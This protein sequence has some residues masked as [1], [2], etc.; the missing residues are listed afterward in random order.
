LASCSTPASLGRP[1]ATVGSTGMETRHASAHI[2]G[3]VGRTDCSREAWPK[4]SAAVPCRSHLIAAAHVCRGP[5]QDSPAFDPLMPQAARNVRF[6]RVPA[7]KAYD[8]GHNHALCRR[9][10]GVRTTAIP[11]NPRAHPGRLPKTPCR[12]LMQTRFPRRLYGQ[13]SQAESTF[14]RHKRLLGSALTAK[15]EGRQHNEIRMRVLT[16]NLMLLAGGSS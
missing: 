11:I 8:A 3:C 4:L 7:E 12:R 2:R 9:E 16:H 10:P 14:S 13:R 6:F 1:E 5:T 15:R